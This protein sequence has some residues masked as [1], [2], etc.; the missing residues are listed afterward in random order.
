METI[1]PWT[2][3]VPVG[4][5]LRHRPESRLGLEFSL[6]GP[7]PFGSC[8]VTWPCPRQITLLS[9]AHPNIQNNTGF[10]WPRH[11]NNPQGQSDTNP[12]I[13]IPSGER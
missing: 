6:G 2:S 5:T 8:L 3:I 12:I 4:C 7:R 11:G 13:K 10:I 9:G 1:P